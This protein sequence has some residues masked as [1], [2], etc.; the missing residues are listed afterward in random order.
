MKGGG[1]QQRGAL[2]RHV[3]GGCRRHRFASRDY[4]RGRNT[5]DGAGVNPEGSYLL[6]LQFGG[7]PQ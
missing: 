6:M 4:L 7:L 2:H 1:N 5:P 3:P